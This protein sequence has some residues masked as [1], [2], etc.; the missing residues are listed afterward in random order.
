MRSRDTV[1]AALLSKYDSHLSGWD[2]AG[3]NLDDTKM[4]VIFF[5]KYLVNLK[6]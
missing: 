4:N 5:V 2:Q 1:S 3:R 6:I